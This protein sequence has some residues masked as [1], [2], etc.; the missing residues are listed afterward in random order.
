[1]DC[2][3]G[4]RRANHRSSVELFIW[5]CLVSITWV[6]HHHHML[7]EALSLSPSLSCPSLSSPFSLSFSSLF[8]KCMQTRKLL[9][10]THKKIIIIIIIIILMMNEWPFV[11][12][13]LGKCD[14]DLFFLFSLSFFSRMTFV[15]VEIIFLMTWTKFAWFR[16]H[17]DTVLCLYVG[18][19]A[20][21]SS[22]GVCWA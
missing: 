4:C 2:T 15:A 10:S 7:A 21:S 6:H 8:L 16:I 19:G 11:F 1:M 3:N 5:S 20:L 18:G 14:R 17:G 12:K 13:D 22:G 9:L